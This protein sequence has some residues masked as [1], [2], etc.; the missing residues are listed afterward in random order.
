MNCKT[1][2][3]LQ[4]DFHQNVEVMG[5]HIWKT[6]AIIKQLMAKL[7]LTIKQIKQIRS[8][9]C[10]FFNLNKRVNMY[11]QITIQLVNL[12]SKIYRTERQGPCKEFV[13][14]WK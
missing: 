6:S 10:V 3:M 12:N 7:V 11:L 13:T 14:C 5:F 8:G 4:I 9:H 2:Y 1:V